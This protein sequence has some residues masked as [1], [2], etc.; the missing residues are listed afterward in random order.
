MNRTEIAARLAANHKIFLEQI[1]RL[2]DT[3]LCY[4]PEGKWTA[5]QQLDHIIRSV[6]PVN[7]AM[8]LPKFIL[9]WKFGTANRPSKTY[10][11]LVEKY[12]RKLLEG[13]RASARFTPPAITADQKKAL[14]HKLQ[15][16]V[17]ALCNKTNHHSEE[18]LDTYI[19]PHPLLGKLTLREMLY[20]TAH[21]V[22]H[23]LEAVNKNLKNTNAE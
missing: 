12:H 15:K 5:I 14:V 6:S 9:K 10:E 8:G 4:A 17:Q 21:H 13:G 3:D 23:H 1:N 2:S 22:L 18:T 19:L 16:L 7:M 20:F 11:Q